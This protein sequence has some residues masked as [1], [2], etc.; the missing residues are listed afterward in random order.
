MDAVSGMQQKILRYIQRTLDE[1]G[2]APSVREIGDALH[3]QGTI[4]VTQG[5]DRVADPTTTSGPVRF[6]VG[7]SFDS[8]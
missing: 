2:V 3:Q 7:P 8:G 1:R 6:R 4:D 5:G